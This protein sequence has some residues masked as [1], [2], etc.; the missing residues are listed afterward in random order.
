MV[1]YLTIETQTTFTLRDKC[2][3]THELT[4]GKKDISSVGQSLALACRGNEIVRTVEVYHADD[5]E[6][7]TDAVCY[8]EAYK[9][10]IRDGFSMVP[11]SINS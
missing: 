9:H 2:A 5:E 3:A 10:H 7:H 8:G 4:G 1:E 6:R 11:E